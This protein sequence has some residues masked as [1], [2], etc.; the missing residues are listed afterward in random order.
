MENKENLETAP[1]A[2]NEE[3]KKPAKKRSPVYYILLSVFAAVFIFSGI[4]VARYFVLSERVS[5]EYEDMDAILESIRAELNIDRD[6]LPPVPTTPDG[7]PQQNTVILPEFK[8]FYEQNP[9]I[10]GW[11]QI[12]GTK[13]DYPVMASRNGDQDYYLNHT[14]KH[15]ESE[16]G[17]IYLRR[18]ESDVFKPSDNV[19]IY[20]HHMKD[21]SMF[22][23]INNY[24][25]SESYW[26]SHR[27][28]YFDTLY[29]RHTYEVFA[30]FVTS[31]TYGLGFNYNNYTN[32]ADGDHFN[33]FVNK[34][35]E[36]SR[37]DYGITPTYGDK[38]LCLSTCEYTTQN[39][40]LVVVARRIS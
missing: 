34:V 9:D 14:F 39:G 13:V 20:G 35:K 37:W 27:Y 7:K 21:G 12:P 11:I 16:W 29:E 33:Q 38:L 28:V 10:V 18:S 23:D 8:L 3:T 31:G 40:R 4:Y 17:A 36:L 1:V 26:N 2:E 5:G 30:V 19:T 22:E 32:F 15:E 25:W 6:N 24:Y